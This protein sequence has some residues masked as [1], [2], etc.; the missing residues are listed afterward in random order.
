[1][2]DVTLTLPRRCRQ[3][4]SHGSTPSLQHLEVWLTEYGWD[5]NPHS[6]LAALAYG[7]FTAEHVQGMWL[8]RGFMAGLEAG[9]DRMHIFM[10]RN[11]NDN[12]YTKYG[13][14]SMAQCLFPPPP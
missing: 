10:L 8:V 1:M 13:A 14:H 5:T 11:V 3:I 2:Q 9:L 12:G 4:L 6:E 7:D